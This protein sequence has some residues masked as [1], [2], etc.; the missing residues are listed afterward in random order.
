MTLLRRILTE[1]R[2]AAYVLGGLL[3]LNVLVFAVFVYPLQR[4]VANVE[5]RTRDAEAALAAARADHAQASGTLE[6]RDR[7]VTELGTFYASVLPSSLAAA[8]RLTNVEL[9]RLASDAGVSWQRA[10]YSPEIERGSTLT[11]LGGSL[12]LRGGY[13][14][15]RAFLHAVESAPEFIVIE[16]LVLFEQAEGDSVLQAEVELSTYFPRSDR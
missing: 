4:D 12:L 9:E 7:A 15:V 8:R 3:V 16:N 10:V 2:R 6:G 11:R 14:D 5:Q 13:D 1:H